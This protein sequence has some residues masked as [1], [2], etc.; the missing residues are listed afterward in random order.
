MARIPFMPV[1]RCS[2]GAVEAVNDARRQP[3][4]ESTGEA[5]DASRCDSVFLHVCNGRR[6]Y[7][8]VAAL[9][10]TSLILGGPEYAECEVAPAGAIARS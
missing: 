7:I 2:P 6:C 10:G 3:E 5:L 1:A 9:G 8:P 4:L